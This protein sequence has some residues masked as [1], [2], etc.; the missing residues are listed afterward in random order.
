MNNREI[1]NGGFCIHRGSGELIRHV[2]PG[3]SVGCFHALLLTGQKRTKKTVSVFR[4][5]VEGAGVLCGGRAL[6]KRKKTI[7]NTKGTV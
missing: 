3:H 7:K 6:L 1:L 2:E 5:W 4:G